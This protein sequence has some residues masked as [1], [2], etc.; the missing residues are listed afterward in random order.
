[1]YDNKNCVQDVDEIALSSAVM[2]ISFIEFLYT[3]VGFVHQKQNHKAIQDSYITSKEQ[4][5]NLTRI[6]EGYQVYTVFTI[7]PF[8]IVPKLLNRRKSRE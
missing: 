7:T 6:D 1:M 3:E 4:I 5:S 2:N 8:G